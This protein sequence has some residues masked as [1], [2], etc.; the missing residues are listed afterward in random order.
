MSLFQNTLAQQSLFSIINAYGSFVNLRS[1]VKK[2]QNQESIYKEKAISQ[3]KLN[4]TD[5]YS[6]S[7]QGISENQISEISNHIHNIEKE[8]IEFLVQELIIAEKH[9]KKL[10]HQFKNDFPELFEEMISIL[11]QH[12]EFQSIKKNKTLINNDIINSFK[13]EIIS[14]LNSSFGL[15][16]K[17]QKVASNNFFS[18]ILSKY[19]IQ[20]N[21]EHINLIIKNINEN[22]KKYQ[23]NKNDI[24]V[25]KE[26]LFNFLNKVNE[27]DINNPDLFMDNINNKLNPKKS[28]TAKNIVHKSIEKYKS[29][30]SKLATI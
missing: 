8:N 24:L 4:E 1:L 19:D 21:K 30:L 28:D 25:L 20:Y 11:E 2:K 14:F 12:I 3:L 7:E 9:Y 5:Y 16:N 23:V 17:G 15:W 13:Q 27:D 18:S 29:L 6:E 22:E 10:K 26:L